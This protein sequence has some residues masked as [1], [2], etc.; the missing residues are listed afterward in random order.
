MR[1]GKK[2]NCGLEI[3]RFTLIPPNIRLL[4]GWPVWGYTLLYP[5][6]RFDDR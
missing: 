5:V 1:F 2:K 4:A 3:S 6:N